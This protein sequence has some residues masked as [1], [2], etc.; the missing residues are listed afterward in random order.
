VT[1]IGITMVSRYETE[2]KDVRMVVGDTVSVGEG[3]LQLTSMRRS[4]ANTQRLWARLLLRDKQ[5]LKTMHLKRTY[6]S[7]AMPM[8]EAAIDTDCSVTCMSLEHRWVRD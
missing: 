6:L 2:K 8:T 5:K 3:T 1:V 4:G 7:S